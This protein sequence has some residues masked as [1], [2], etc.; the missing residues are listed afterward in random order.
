MG[1]ITYQSFKRDCVKVGK[2]L[3]KLFSH[4]VFKNPKN[5]LEK[6]HAWEP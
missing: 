6:L 4:F 1:N 2:C 3:S 5:S